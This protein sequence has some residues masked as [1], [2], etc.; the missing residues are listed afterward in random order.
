MAFLDKLKETA[1]TIGEKTTEIAKDLGEKT[2]EL[3]K[4]LGEKTSDAIETGKLQAKINTEK[5]AMKEDIRLIGE[6]YYNH[7]VNGGEVI[8]E[9][10]EACGNAK[11]HAD[12][13]E[14]LKAEIERIKTEDT[15]DTPQ[16]AVE[17][18]VEEVKEVVEEV[19]DKV[20]EV[21]EKVEDKVEEVVDKVEDVI[22][23][24]TE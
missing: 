2:T 18:V 19:I 4:D 5:N 12:K 15:I 1:K 6:F 8:P 13:I 9:A 16:E 20:E 7:F 23:G 14:E 21:A 3:A 22:E 11:A 17:E 24:K 10:L